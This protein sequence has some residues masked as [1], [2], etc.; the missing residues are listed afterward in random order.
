MRAA[1]T[2]GIVAV[3]V[4]LVP[5]IPVLLIGWGI[6]RLRTGGSGTG[7]PVAAIVTGALLAALVWPALL[8]DTTSPHTSDGSSVA[9]D[10]GSDPAPSPT[11][12][13]PAVAAPSDSDQP[14]GSD[15]PNEPDGSDG[16]HAAATASP[17]GSATTGSPGAP[18]QPPVAG[19][20]ADGAPAGTPAGSAAAALVP[21]VGVVDGDT[22]RVRVGGATERVRLIGID[23]PELAGRECYAQQ[24]A[25]RMQSL[26]QGRSVRLARDTTQADRDRY[27]RLLRHVSLADGTL[28][29]ERLIDGG[30]GR[31]Y[32]YAAP[33]QH[34]AR[35]RSA[36][37]RAQNAGRG[38]WGNGCPTSPTAS[39]SPSRPS[40][41][42]TSSPV[43]SRARATTPPA[44]IGGCRIKGNINAEGERIYH[45][46]GGRSYDA[47]K[48]D[49]SKGERWFCSESEAAAAGW[50]KAR[51]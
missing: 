32:T 6:L 46:P 27:G 35:Y 7:R 19:I 23:A 49:T 22:L 51:G 2:I 14:N 8:S 16:L 45:V 38:I 24:A 42:R 30:F 10:R 25:S 18:S 37:A 26:V 43:T 29:A 50:R 3:G 44:H 11:P 48:I 36:Q 1:K 40:A 34:Q 15:Q 20:G 17:T 47:T 39:A 5:L 41:T 9:A 4:L 13:D 31:E 33:Y 28:V 12:G 21:V